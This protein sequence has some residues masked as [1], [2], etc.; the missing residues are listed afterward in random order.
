MYFVIVTVLIGGTLFF[1]YKQEILRGLETFGLY[2]R[3]LGL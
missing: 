2:I 1:I 3:G